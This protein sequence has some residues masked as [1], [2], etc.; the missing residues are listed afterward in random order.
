MMASVIMDKNTLKLLKLF[1]RITSTH[2]LTFAFHL[3]LV[4]II[5][6]LQENKIKSP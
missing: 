1:V 5:F 4:G 2:H 3:E 6:R